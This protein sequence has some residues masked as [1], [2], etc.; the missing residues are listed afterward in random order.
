M[1][2]P[3]DYEDIC[4]SWLAGGYQDDPEV[5]RLNLE[6]ELADTNDRT[7]AADVLHG[8]YDQDLESE[9][10]IPRPDPD[11]LTAMFSNLR[12][13]FPDWLDD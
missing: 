3:H 11:K 10:G 1:T 12:R 2:D 4:K 8:W 9:T 6:K 7:F 13:R 5:Y